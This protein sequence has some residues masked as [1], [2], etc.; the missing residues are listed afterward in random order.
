[1]TSHTTLAQLDQMAVGDVASLPIDHLAMLLETIAEEKARVKRLDDHLHNALRTRFADSAAEARR[2][3]GIDTGT[4]RLTD[5]DYTVI[6]DLPKKVVYDQAGLA[7][8]ERELSEM[9]EPVTD[10]ITIKRDVPERAY[11]AWP[12]SLKKM[13]EPYRTV[14]VGKPTFKLEQRKERT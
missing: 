2:T 5:G 13:F 3:K 8:V 9:G 14:D 4:V 11:G 7:L 1:M 6:A 12:A 10:Y